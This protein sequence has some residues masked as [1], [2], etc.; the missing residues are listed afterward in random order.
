MPEELGVDSDEY[1]NRIKTQLEEDRSAREERAK[2]RRKVMVDQ[3]KAHEAQ[4]VYSIWLQF[5]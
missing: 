4:E 2:R 5:E 3:M 1:L